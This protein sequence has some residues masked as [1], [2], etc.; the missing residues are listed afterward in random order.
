MRV[1]DKYQLTSMK[2]RLREQ[3]ALAHSP[4]SAYTNPLG[5]L[6]A[7]TVH[8]FTSDTELAAKAASKKYDFATVDDL[9]KLIDV[10]PATSALVKLVGILAV[11]TRVL[12]EVLFQFEHAPMHLD[13]SN[14]ESLACAACRDPYK[15]CVRQGAPEWQIRWARWIFDR[16]KATPMNTWKT[17]FNHSMVSTA[18]YQ[19]HLAVAFHAYKSGA[20]SRDCTCITQILGAPSQFQGW[21]TGIHEHLKMKLG[22]IANHEARMYET[23]PKG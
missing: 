22:V 11:K 7:T 15:G 18:F 12:A 8:G 19:P 21:A 9:V 14:I 17:L 6:C 1:A 2:V 4:V 3:L 10:E 20:D 5:A 16:T 13:N 23:D